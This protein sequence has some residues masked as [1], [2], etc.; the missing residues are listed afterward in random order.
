MTFNELEFKTHPM[1]SGV[2]ATH[3]FPNGIKVSV[4]GGAGF[5]GDGVESFE[6]AALLPSGGFLPLGEDDDVLGW[7]TKSEIDSLLQSISQR[8]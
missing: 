3:V 1:G 5:Y 2:Q 8:K 4:V 6:M 7:V